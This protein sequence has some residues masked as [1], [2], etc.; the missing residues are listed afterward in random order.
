MTFFDGR[1]PVPGGS[2]DNH[3]LPRQSLLLRNGPG[4]TKHEEERHH[5]QGTSFPCAVRNMW[6]YRPV[7]EA[8]VELGE[9]EEYPS[10]KIPGFTERL[11]AWLPSLVEHRCNYGER[12]GFCAASGKAPGPDISSNTSRSNCKIWPD[13]PVASARPARLRNTGSKGRRPR[14]AR[15]GHPT[16]L[17]MARRP[18]HGGHRGQTFDVAGAIDELGDMVDSKC[19]GPSTASIVDA[20]DDRDIPTIRLLADGNSV[21]IG[22]GAAMRRIWTAETDRTSAIAE[23]ISRDKDLTRNSSPPAASRFPKAARSPAPPMPGRPPRRSGCR[24]ASSR[25]TATMAGRLHRRQD[26]RRSRE[27]VLVAIDEGS[28]VLVERSIPGTDIACW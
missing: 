20:A 10:N 19:L 4:R 23:T 25:A 7:L 16:A 14:L 2:V 9:L 26:P 21:Q 1:Q 3:S 27:G 24:S 22:Y 17:H 8:W 28:A 11:A 5:H 18:D 6:T 15:G 12:G 13:S